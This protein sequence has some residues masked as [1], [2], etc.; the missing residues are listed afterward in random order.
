MR[1][2]GAQ[3]IVECGITKTPIISTD[4]GIA[5]ISLQRVNF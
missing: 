5:M 2:E 1:L 3:A 4:V